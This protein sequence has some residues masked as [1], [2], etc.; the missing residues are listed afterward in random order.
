MRSYN[1]EHNICIVGNKGNLG[2]FLEK[3]LI[4]LLNIGNIYGYDIEVKDEEKNDLLD[5]STDIIL[6]V[7]LGKYINE[8]KKIISYLEKNINLKTLWLIPSVQEPVANLVESMYKKSYINNL[9]VVLAHPMYGPDSFVDKPILNVVTNIFNE[10][11]VDKKISKIMSIV[12]NAKITTEFTPKKHDEITAKSQGLV[13][14]FSKIVLSDKLLSYEL[15]KFHNK[16]Y[17]VII[18]DRCL[19]NDFL[20]ENKYCSDID[21][22]FNLKWENIEKKSLNSLIKCFKEVDFIF[23]KKTNKI[24]LEQ[25]IYLRNY[26]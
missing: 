22:F 4:P 10:K 9:S 25:Y 13:Y 12:L 21:Y 26:E 15:K 8:T 17:K 1:I 19:I 6:C 14:V 2:F 7:P 20:K 3:T 18:S 11:I 24:P 23:N 16:F 5:K